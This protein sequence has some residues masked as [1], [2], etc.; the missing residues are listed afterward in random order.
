L[1]NWWET[2]GIK[3]VLLPAGLGYYMKTFFD[4]DFE[5]YMMYAESNNDEWTTCVD[6]EDW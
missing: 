3:S 1:P 4:L 5:G 6:F 2:P